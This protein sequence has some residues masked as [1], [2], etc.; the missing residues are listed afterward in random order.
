LQCLQLAAFVCCGLIEQQRG[1]Q[2]GEED[3]LYLAWLQVKLKFLLYTVCRGNCARNR[4]AIAN[5]GLLFYF[6]ALS[7]YFFV[8]LCFS[9][10]F[11][12]CVTLFFINLLLF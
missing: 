3:L 7:Y 10:Y 1:L 12:N 5:G 2:K 4:L 9:L 6:S 11:F 8:S